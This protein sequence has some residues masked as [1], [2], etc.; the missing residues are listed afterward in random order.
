M[1]GF[2]FKFPLAI[3]FLGHAVVFWLLFNFVPSSL[4]VEEVAIRTEVL[5]VEEP[6]PPLPEKKPK[7]SRKRPVAKRSATFV[8]N[9]G[10][11]VVSP[12]PEPFVK[13]VSSAFPAE[14]SPVET[15]SPQIEPPSPPVGP[16]EVS[17]RLSGGILPIPE[18]PRLTEKA[19]P[20]LTRRKNGEEEK[21]VSRTPR[22][23]EIG[24]ADPVPGNEDLESLP[25]LSLT[26]PVPSPQKGL[27]PVREPLLE[28]LAVEDE[29]ALSRETAPQDEIDDSLLT[30]PNDPNTALDETSVVRK[31]VFRLEENY[32]KRVHEKVGSAWKL[33]DFAKGKKFL[34]QI[35]AV[36]NKKGEVLRLEFVKKAE[37]DLINLAT[38]NTILDAVPFPPM[39]AGFPEDKVVRITFQFSDR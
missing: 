35:R 36:L 23:F 1:E 28:P 31:E 14:V 6:A 38:R 3:S 22:P 17:P 19:L 10:K 39:P 13:K 2:S 16:A 29:L 25:S 11:K 18:R 8:P 33:P 5:F 26:N 12:Q 20:R 37:D 15:E 24:D 4:G 34:I 9:A 30:V 32:K 27:F 21:A 7:T